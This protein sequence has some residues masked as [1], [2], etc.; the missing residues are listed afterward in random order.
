MSDWGHD[1]DD[2][3]I[4][5]QPIDVDDDESSARAEPTLCYGSVDEFVREYLRNV[6]RRRIDGRTPVLG[7][8][9]VAL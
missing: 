6:Y 2:D 3:G 4:E 9:V 7:G 8:G 5:A 1:E